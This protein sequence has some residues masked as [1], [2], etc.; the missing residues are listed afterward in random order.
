MVRDGAAAVDRGCLSSNVLGIAGGAPW[1]RSTAAT[2]RL[3]AQRATTQQHL[4]I[5][6]EQLD[7]WRDERHTVAHR[8]NGRVALAARRRH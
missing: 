1:R 5:A 3:V 6:S 8:V 2:R 7:Q 4:I